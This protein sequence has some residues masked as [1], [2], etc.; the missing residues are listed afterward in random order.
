[1]TGG[2]KNREAGGE[3]DRGSKDV[4]KIRNKKIKEK[5]KEKKAGTK[6]KKRKQEKG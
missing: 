4:N 3:K 5:E 6:E 2:R 1:M